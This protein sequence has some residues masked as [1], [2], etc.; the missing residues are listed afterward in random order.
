MRLTRDALQ[1]AAGRARVWFA[2]QE[3]YGRH[4]A[5][6]HAAAR[7]LRG[8]E[9]AMDYEAAYRLLTRIEFAHDCDD[10]WWA[11]TDGR[12]IWLNT[13]APWSATTLEWTL[14]HEAMHNTIVRCDGGGHRLPEEKE[15]RIMRDV[16][17]SLA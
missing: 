3:S 10:V 7:H 15:H 6:H 5:I 12:R 14:I 8:A 11:E 16:S 17:P 9:F 4:S 13:Y 1:R 2:A